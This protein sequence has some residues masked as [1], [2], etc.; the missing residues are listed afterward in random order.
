MVS[1]PYIDP[2]GVYFMQQV[3]LI[4]AGSFGRS[5]AWEYVL[6]FIAARIGQD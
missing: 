4:E 1:I 2:I 6:V 3:C 5:F